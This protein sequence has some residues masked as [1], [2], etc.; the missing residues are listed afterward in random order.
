[1]I[2]LL[3]KVY[4][5]FMGYFPFFIRPPNM[6][7]PICKF[8]ATDLEKLNQVIT[9]IIYMQCWYYT[10]ATETKLISW[11]SVL[12]IFIDDF[13][14]YNIKIQAVNE[15]AISEAEYLNDVLY[16]G[17]SKITDASESGRGEKSETSKVAVAG[18]VTGSVL[19]LVLVLV[20]FLFLRKRIQNKKREE[21]VQV[22]IHLFKFAR[23]RACNYN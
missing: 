22:Y 18:G 1:M 21:A 10:T 2:L 13:A 9:I 8:T 3:R 17:I 23:C 5:M 16:P 19:F 15:V 4:V 11:I 12:F 6:V 7:N 14:S 20:A